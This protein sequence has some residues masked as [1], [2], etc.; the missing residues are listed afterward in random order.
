MEYYFDEH[1]FV[2]TVRLRGFACAI[3]LYPGKNSSLQAFNPA[4]RVAH[5][6]S[7]FLRQRGLLIRGVG[8]TLFIA[9]P[10]CINKLEI[11]FLCQHAS[12]GIADYMHEFVTSKSGKSLSIAI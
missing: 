12:S 7:L 5:H 3:D 9:P 1:P 4:E 2:K 8:N 6:C 11:D 10:L